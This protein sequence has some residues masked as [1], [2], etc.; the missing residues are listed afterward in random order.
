MP[1]T[2][3]LVFF[4]NQGDSLNFKYNDFY[5][6]YEGDLLFDENGND[7]FKTIGLYTFEYVPSYEYQLPGQLGL[8]KFQLF[9]E[10]KFN[11]SG[12]SYSNQSVQLIDIP[13]TD[14]NFY[15]K[16]IYG[17]HFESKFPIGSQIKFNNP[18]FEFTNPDQNYTVVE[19]KKDA[20]M[21]ISNVDNSTYDT[22]YSTVMGL[23]SSYVN[24]TISGINAIGIYNYA[25]ISLN[26]LLSQWSEP[27]FF[28]KYYV[29]KKL[30]VLNTEK[31]DGVYTVNNI[32]LFDRKYQKY[33]LS[34]DVFTA[35]QDL[36]VEVILLTE[37]PLIYSG[38]LN[39]TGNVLN[40]SP[41]YAPSNLKPGIEF[42]IPTSFLNTD[43]YTIDYIPSFL[44]NNTLTYYDVNAQVIWNNK[45]YQC[46]Q[47]YTWSGTSS[48][49]PDNFVYWDRPTYLPI[50]STFNTETLPSAEI[51]LTTNVFAYTQSFTQSNEIT[52]ATFAQKYAQDFT[53]FNINL[54]YK[55]HALHS[56]LIYPSNYAEVNYYPYVIATS[57]SW[58]ST[59]LILEQTVGI[60]ENLKPEIATNT[61]SRPYYNIVFDELDEFGIIITI[62]GHKYQVEI[63]Y[64][65]V[66]LTLNMPRTIDKT[67]RLWLS[68]WYSRLYSIGV[69]PTLQYRGTLSSI[70]YNS[71][72]FLADYPNVPCDFTIEVG[73]VGSYYI[74]HSDIL[75]SNIGPYLTININ[76]KNY[77]QSFVTSISNTIT[78]WVDTWKDILLS[79]GII[80]SNINSLLIFRVK[81]QST[82]CVYTINTNKLTLPGIPDYVITNRIFGNF[83]NTITSNEIIL[84]SGATDSFINNSF[85]SGQV[86]TINNTVR[87]WDNQGFN[88]LHIT[89]NNLVLSYQGPFWGTVPVPCEVSP[90]VNLA[91]SSGFSATGCEPP[92]IP[93]Y[94][95]DGGEFDLHEYDPS[96]TLHFASTN[97]Y[98]SI[99][100][101]LSGNTNLVDILYVQLTNCV[102]VL[103][104]NL[105]VIDSNTG[106][107]VNTIDLAPI[108]YLI[109]N[110]Y[111]M[112][113]N[114]VNSYIYIHFN[115]AGLGGHGVI[116]IDILTNTVVQT[117]TSSYFS[118]TLIDDM[119]VNTTNGD[120]FISHP[121]VSKYDWIASSL[122]I[123]SNIVSGTTH[124]MIYSDFENAI[125]ILVD[126]GLVK[127]IKGIS[128]SVIDNTF[129]ITGLDLEK[130]G[131]EPINGSVYVFDT[132]GLV[133]IRNNTITNLYSIAY[134]SGFADILF[135]NINGDV[136]ISQQGTSTY[137]SRMAL[138]GTL[139]SQSSTTTY[140]YLTINQYDGDV[141]VGSLASNQVV[142]FDT[143]HGTI[144]HTE[145][146]AS[147]ITKLSYNPNRRSIWGIEPGGNTVV[148]IGVYVNSEVVPV[149]PTYSMV[150]EDNYG[151][152]ASDYIKP[153][154][155][156]LKTREYIRRPRENYQGDTQ[157]QYVWKWLDDTKPQM[158]LYD[159]T[160]D[161]LVYTNTGSYSYLG[162]TPLTTITL[163]EN[164]NKDLTKVYLPEY[165]QTVFE[166][167]VQTLDYIDSSNDISINPIPLETFMGFKGDDE[168]PMDQYLLLYKRDTAS[169]SIVSNSLDIVQFQL[170]E[171]NVN[172][173][174]GIIA[175]SLGSSM[176]FSDN[177]FKPDQ[178][179]QIFVKDITNQKNKY[180][181][182]NNGKK[183]KIRTVFTYYLVVDFIDM[184]NNEFSKID[185][186]PT[187]GQETYLQVDI[188]SIDRE[189]GRFHVYGQTE[190][191]DIRYE[192]ELS[193]T[194]HNIL[195]DDIFIFKSYDVNEQGIDWGFMNK[196]RKEMLMVRNQIFPY[197]GSYKAII[198]AINYFGYNDLQLYEYYRNININSPLFYKLFKVEI[199]DI[200]DNSV[201]GWTVNDFIKHTMPNPN[202]ETTNLF[203]LTYLITDK[204]GNDVLQYSLQEVIMKLEGL[205]HWLE[206]KVIPITHK[207]LDITGR[208][209]FVGV[210]SIVH[211]NYDVKILNA[212]QEFTPID[213]KLNEAYLQPVNSGSTV[214]T[215][216]VDFYNAT[217]S[218]LPDYFT[219]RIRTYQT[220]Q[221][222]NPFTT[223]NTGDKVSYYGYLYESVI[224]QNKINDPR[225]YDSMATK[226]TA[227]V[228][229]QLGQMAKYE[230]YTY[231]YIGTQS[232][233]VVF[234]T[235]SIPTPASDINT[236]HSLANWLDITQWKV[237]NYVPVQ[238][239]FE[240]RTGTQSF[241]FTID[242]NIDPFILIEVTSDNGYGQIYTSKKNYEIRG[243]ND[244]GGTINYI[245]NIG[246]FIPIVQITSPTIGY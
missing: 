5:K 100:Y 167:V 109:D 61:C 85:S 35:S 39:L 200:F 153:D 80:V 140:G 69:I 21:I 77:G 75:F 144:K 48:I 156:W 223:Y 23:T 125:Y 49:T 45:V 87:P 199:P 93:P 95:P 215:C 234:G 217:S 72:N 211:R 37:P 205:K 228:D 79:Y 204:E 119:V 225:K 7:T 239:I 196:K 26:P 104:L 41:G 114:P 89:D 60:K 213:F 169:M 170:I 141:Y 96:F 218:V 216:H 235:S 117:L 152:L 86:V 179:I 123:N 111:S 176:N 245:E 34:R 138:D 203:N 38:H 131:Y 241:N 106:L 30:T 46:I 18:V 83:G 154:E 116:V 195:P 145:S 130:I 4:N 103:G 219:I 244:L 229:Y 74:E 155:L 166:N 9:N 97:N 192:I 206:R 191:E 121:D 158:F 147:T 236:N 98:T 172:G 90:F 226:W 15:S 178:W 29:G 28:T 175:L 181:S 198:N 240:Y 183:F 174:Y 99:L 11:I 8:D 135:N 193:N 31:N 88:L 190:I 232:S 148:E 13:N 132:T 149:T 47:S 82:K 246:P 157:I 227:N 102:Y 59:E 6:R 164:P 222:W 67:L 146:F 17:T 186:Y 194:G 20:I 52:L 189:I 184:I 165:Q 27:L 1:Q 71:I 84:P 81:T 105:T 238:N 115:S 197:I 159:F 210:D 221:E 107:V 201:K 136:L 171:D 173:W 118:S 53:A 55:D 224:D 209:D 182:T 63:D 220:Y 70:Y 160:G 113:Y 127:R 242:S 24:V 122:V 92:I 43:Y 44:G 212:R 33:S 237:I 22:L 202:Y 14:S 12:C 214:Y 207:I 151:T 177:G 16:W 129:S 64:V 133:Q 143:V 54:Y 56:D 168:G 231:E 58:G 112:L 50:T 94:N 124:K 40:F 243:L 180:I 161:Q 62:N 76:G 78:L 101:P 25:D 163:N 36:A 32:N 110:T 19:T 120:V 108:G 10:T 230:G 188:K 128:P 68:L 208:A 57:S 137:Y 187:V 185:D 3:S 162:P 139:I 51:H 66:G 233:Y 150:T 42:S 73:S 142:V 126:S 134:E 65:Y 91:F 2:Q